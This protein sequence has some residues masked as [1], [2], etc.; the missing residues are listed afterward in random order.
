MGCRSSKNA[1]APT[2]A[3]SQPVQTNPDETKEL[4]SGE[5][6]PTIHLP[7]GRA[8]IAQPSAQARP[9]P[10]P[11]NRQPSFAPRVFLGYRVDS[12]KDLVE[13][14]YDKLQARGVDV[15]WDVRCLTPGQPWEEGFANG[16]A[17]SDVFVPVLSKA[18]L[19]RYEELTPESECDNVLLEHQLALEL[20]KRGNLDKILPVFV[21]ELG[22]GNIS[23]PLHPSEDDIQQRQDDDEAGTC[24]VAP[25]GTRRRSSIDAG[26]MYG[27]FFI[28]G[29][30][31]K[32]PEFVVKAVDQK[33]SEHLQRLGMGAPQLLEGERTV[34][35]T[36]ESIIA[37]QGVFLV[38]IKDAA[39]QKVV[40]YIVRADGGVTQQMKREI[41][42]TPKMMGAGFKNVCIH[43]ECI[44]STRVLACRR[45]L[46]L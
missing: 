2:E 25:A 27:D 33:L 15:W 30:M 8:A 39:M 42:D 4:Q 44:T 1:S 22:R 37:H 18:A 26:E 6:G 43:T 35:S 41:R 16:L 20:K 38:G 12:D 3:P 29:S 46:R 13:R 24:T 17:G 45:P 23:L 28:G 5:A 14:L 36:L 19:K 31:P 32:S 34:K 9:K 21:G 10:P 11:L 40:D 7:P